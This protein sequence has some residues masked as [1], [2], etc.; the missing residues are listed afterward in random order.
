M[1]SNCAVV[2]GHLFRQGWLTLFSE[3]DE[4]MWKD[5]YE[6]FMKRTRSKY[7]TI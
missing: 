3:A 5:K 1:W 4:K 7:L 6:L 2:I